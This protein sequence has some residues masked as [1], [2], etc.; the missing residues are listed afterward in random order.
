MTVT[1]WGV[2][3]AGEPHAASTKLARTN[4]NSRERTVLVISFLLLIF[5]TMESYQPVFKVKGRMG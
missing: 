2:A 4:T 1:V 5:M 3:A